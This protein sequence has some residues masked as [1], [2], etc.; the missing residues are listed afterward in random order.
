[1]IIATNILKRSSVAAMKTLIPSN[2][3]D[4]TLAEL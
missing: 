2:S 1:M 4:I 3:S